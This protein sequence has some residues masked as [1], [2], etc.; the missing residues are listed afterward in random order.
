ML[1]ALVLVWVLLDLGEAFWILEFLQRG[2]TR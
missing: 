2:V 1:M